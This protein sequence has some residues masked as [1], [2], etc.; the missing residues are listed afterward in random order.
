MTALSKNE[1]IAT[2][3]S[4]CL[5]NER[6]TEPL[7][8]ISNI[9]YLVIKRPNIEKAAKFFVDYGLLVDHRSA[10]TIYL[11]GT[12]EQSHCVIIE[13]GAASISRLGFTASEE[14]VKNLAAHFNLQIKAH[15]DPIGGQ[16]VSLKDPNNLVLEI[17]CNTPSLLP[18][19]SSQEKSTPPSPWNHAGQKNRIN[20]NVKKDI[21]PI[22]IHKLGHSLFSVADIK[23][24]VHW[25]QNTLGMIVSD[26]QFLENDPL[27]VVAF[28]R[29]DNGKDASDHHTLGLGAAVE[30][31]HQHS[32]F[33]L[34]T[35]EEIAIAN[36]WMKQNDYKHGWGIGRHKLGSQIFDYWRDSYGDLFEHY[37]DGDLFNNSA[38]TG[39]HLFNSDAQHQW[40]PDMTAEFSGINRPWRLVKSIIRRMRS[41]ENFSFGRLIRLAKAA[42]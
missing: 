32:A 23:E 16:Y 42:T 27:P 14:D 12:S 36:D 34:D 30:L 31:G 2:L 15:S 5:V 1:P 6:C 20:K 17:N 8:K 38:K 9:T 39:Y 21:E 4:E 19:K 28:M 10:D 18:L 3:K 41:N 33:E 40:G 29:C 25:Y 35:M 7:A 37:A 26:F 24:T 22:V 13:E 11:R